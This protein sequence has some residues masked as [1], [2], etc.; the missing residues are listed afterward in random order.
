[1]FVDHLYD[2][3]PFKSSFSSRK[4]TS[5][6]DDL[7]RTY[8]HLIKGKDSNSASTSSDGAESLDSCSNSGMNESHVSTMQKHVIIPQRKQKESRTFVEPLK[9]KKVEQ[10]HFALI[11]PITSVVDAE[12]ET[13][14]DLN[15]FSFEAN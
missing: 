10:E 6:K 12:K 13:K 15:K 14:N 8:E 5:I 9:A 2:F 4:S 1:M 3:T 7:G 11:D